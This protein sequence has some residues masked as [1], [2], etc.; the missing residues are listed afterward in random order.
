MSPANWNGGTFSGNPGVFAAVDERSKDLT[1]AFRQA[2]AGH[3]NAASGAVNG[4]HQS[5]TQRVK[6][7]D[8]LPDQAAAE[9]IIQSTAVSAA[10]HAA[11]PRDVVMMTPLDNGIPLRNRQDD[12][13]REVEDQLDKGVIDRA[14]DTVKGWFR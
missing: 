6:N 11:S 14:A 9:H 7:R 10:G 3:F 1:E 4:Q 13:R 8:E 2:I 12:I 5:D